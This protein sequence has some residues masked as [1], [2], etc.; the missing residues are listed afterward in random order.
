MIGRKSDCVYPRLPNVPCAE[1]W[2]PR[3][4]AATQATGTE[5]APCQTP[6]RRIHARNKTAQNPK[7]SAG[8]IKRTNKKV[9]EPIVRTSSHRLRLPKSQ[10]S[11]ATVKA[12]EARRRGA[13][14]STGN[15]ASQVSHHNGC[16]PA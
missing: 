13:A 6:P 16:R 8:Q 14:T 10:A 1:T 3:N 11:T 4:S 9:V 2:D 12:S 7:V 15:G 5:R